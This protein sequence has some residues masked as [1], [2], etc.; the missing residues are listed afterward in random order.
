MG[1][2]IFQ[3]KLIYHPIKLQNNYEFQFNFEYEELFMQSTDGFKLNGI[4]AKLDTSKG[5]IFFLHGSGGNVERYRNNIPKYLKLNYDMFLLDYRGYGKSEGKIKSENQFF[6]DIRIAYDM[7]KSRYN[8]DQI[9]VIGFSLGTIPAAK[10]AGEKNPRL[11]ILESPHYS[12]IE[13]AKEKFPFLPVSIISKYKFEVFRYIQSVASPIVIF[14]GKQDES[15]VNNSIRLEEFLKPGDKVIIL[16]GEG[17]K[18][19]IFNDQYFNI[20]K[21]LL[22]N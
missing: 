5:V 20:V 14:C 11:L 7:L 22:S 3:N 15:D 1:L 12:L 8:E 6:N 17:H 10:I 2:Y 16:E 18:D 4:L 21:D 19:F 9:V 13:S